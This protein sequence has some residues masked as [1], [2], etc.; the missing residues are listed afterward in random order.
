MKKYIVLH[1]DDDGDMTICFM[2]E[3]EIRKD[4]L[5]D[6]EL[7][8][9]ILDHLPNLGYEEGLLIIEGKIVVPK[10]K[11]KVIKWEL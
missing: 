2:T 5:P 3:D 9:E 11:E 10:A 8:H 6:D 7:P 1:A 4:Y